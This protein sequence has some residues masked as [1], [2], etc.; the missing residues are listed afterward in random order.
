ME[1]IKDYIL[2]ADL[3]EINKA[4]SPPAPKAKPKICYETVF[5]SGPDFAIRRRTAKT[6][7]V[8]VIIISKGQF[9]IKDETAGGLVQNIQEESLRRFVLGIPAEGYTIQDTEGNRPNWISNL[10]RE[11]DWRDRFLRTISNE[12]FYPYMKNNMFDFQLCMDRYSVP[13]LPQ[14]DFAAIKFA[15]NLVADHL[16]RDKAKELLLG[17][18]PFFSNLFAEY[19]SYPRGTQ[20]DTESSYSQILSRWGIE[21]VRQFL[22]MYLETPINSFP[23]G[24]IFKALFARFDPTENRYGPNYQPKQLAKTVFDLQSMVDYMFCECTKQGFADKASDFWTRWADYMNQQVLLFGEVRDKYSEHLASDELILSYRCSKLKMQA[25]MEQFQQA[26]EFLSKYEYSD[27]IYCILA[28]KK[29][30]DL[31][32]EGRQLS[33]C[34][35]SY[36]DRV[37]AMDTYIFFMRKVKEPSHSLVTIQIRSD[38][39][40]GQVSGRFNRQP[41]PD[42]LRFVKYWHKEVFLKKRGQVA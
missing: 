16:G 33:H 28:P 15:F 37:A 42:Q 20:I 13:I 31:V 11:N 3:A 8:M 2:Q 1:N 30:D 6:S 12:A 35:G 24:H 22:T 27:G 40:L 14:A 9:Y 26:S 38:G 10:R 29:P 25:S 21:G 39:S 4:I 34:V 5:A 19:K 32:E 41:T 17:N 7:S 18:S 23:D 36:V